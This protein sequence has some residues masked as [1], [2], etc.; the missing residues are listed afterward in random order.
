MNSSLVCSI[1]GLIASLL[2]SGGF[3]LF[4]FFM[5]VGVVVLRRR[6][7]KVTAKTA[8]QQGVESV[9][10]VFVRGSA[11]LEDFDDDDDDDE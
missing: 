9:S 2:C 5:I 7:K 8:M 1:L 4:V 3:C 11:G 10:Q 6:G